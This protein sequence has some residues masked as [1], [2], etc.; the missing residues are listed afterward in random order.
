MVA[1]GLWHGASW[2]YVVFGAMQGLGLIVNREF[3][4][5][6]K[7]AQPLANVLETLPGR[8]F[9]N[10]FD[11]GVHHCQFCRVS[12]SGHAARL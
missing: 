4:T 2:H 3:K 11:D 10:L 7:V 1:C 8:V 9:W 6:L 12:C 5:F